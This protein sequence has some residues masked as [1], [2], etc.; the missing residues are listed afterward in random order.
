MS[1]KKESDEGPVPM[2]LPEDQFFQKTGMDVTWVK[3]WT[4]TIQPVSAPDNKNLVFMIPALSFA[5]YY[6]LQDMKIRL[7]VLLRDKDDEPLKTTDFICPVNNIG[8]SIFEDCKMYLQETQCSSG[9]NSLYPFFSYLFHMLNFSSDKKKGYLSLQGFTPDNEG[10]WGDLNYKTQNTGFSERRH[11]F[12]NTDSEGAFTYSDSDAW[13]VTFIAPILTD[14]SRVQQPMIAQVGGRI[15][16]TR[17]NASFYLMEKKPKSGSTFSARGAHLKIVGAELMIPVKQM[18]PSLNMKIETH[19][20][21]KPIKYDT[22]RCDLRKYL[23]S[24]GQTVFNCDDLKTSQVSPDRMFFMLI[25]DYKINGL[26]GF[27]PFEF[28]NRIRSEADT[29][30]G[31]PT[32]DSYL[33]S[34]RLTINNESLESFESAT[35]YDTAFRKYME[36]ND[37]LGFTRTS[38]SSISFR[39]NDFFS[40]KFVMA[41]DLTASKCSSAYG[42]NMRG[43]SKD[44]ALK[45]EM[46][47]SKELPCSVWLLCLSEYHSSIT[48]DK[49]RNVVYNYFS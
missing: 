26:N 27:N 12:G 15:E 30:S 43:S 19:L 13:P 18:T 29:T 49:N 14:F 36:T 45:L 23:I 7:N 11:W 9:N 32:N 31:T 44:G 42:A 17:S 40:A 46:R 6:F 25:P 48:I 1:S 3:N 10:D 20:S 16:L 4:M 5:N 47:F 24:R 21:S 34:M 38:D 35:V 2:M 33:Q 28:S 22:I 37:V 8:S 39:P 41:Y